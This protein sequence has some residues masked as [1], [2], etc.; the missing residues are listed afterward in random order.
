ML[1]VNTAKWNQEASDLRELALSAVHPRSRERLMALY[2]IRMEKM[3]VRW[4]E[5]VVAI[6]KR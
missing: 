5:K 1:K 3:P 4:D 2:E 6:L